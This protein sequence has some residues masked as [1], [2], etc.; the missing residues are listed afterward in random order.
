[1][2]TGEKFIIISFENGGGGHRLGRIICSL[3]DVYWY[4]HPDNGKNPWNV[5]FKNTNIRQRHVSKFHFDRLVPKGMLPPTHDYVSKFI[6]DEDE[7]YEKYYNPKFEEMGGYEIIKDYKIL[8]VSHA[9]PEVLSKRFPKAKIINLIG[10]STKIAN[11]YLQTTSLFPAYLKLKWL[12]G[13]NTEYG[14]KLKTISEKLGDKFTVRDVWAY[15]KYEIGYNDTLEEEYNSYVHS[16]IHNNM[17]I[18]KSYSSTN[19]INVDKKDYKC[20]K[21]FLNG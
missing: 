6:P 20:I 12:D 18:R 11:R 5:H 4:T 19:C 1:M 13:E 9:L 2:I 17:N 7:Y 16:M 14:K 21:D 3:P 8:L 15:K 10:D